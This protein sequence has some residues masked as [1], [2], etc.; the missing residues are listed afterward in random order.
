M[1]I[2]IGIADDHQLFLKSLSLLVD[3]FSSFSVCVD[4]VNGD[5][6]LKKL[7]AMPIHPE[8]ILLDV[9]MPVL[10][11]PKTAAILAEKF[12]TI[13]LVALSMKVDD[14]SVIKMIRAGCCAYLL[15][16]IHPTE[17]EKAL[18]EVY[19][20]GYYNA[21][22]SN[23]R[24]RRLLLN[25]LE[26]E[27]MQISARE[28]TFLKLASSDLTYRQIADKMQLAERTI[29]GY[30]ESLFIKLNVQSRV[31]MVLEALRRNLI[32]LEELQ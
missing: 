10:D 14:K 19:H 3:T 29:D 7:E 16:D 25:Q 23:I 21:D 27:R 13:K 1:K 4:A 20:S 22:V 12:P 5:I 6:L 26:E 15:K 31:G 24:Y 8:I 2:G 9:N 11:G 17:L 18:A 30:R 28:A 32:T